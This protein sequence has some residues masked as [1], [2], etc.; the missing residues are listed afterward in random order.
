[1]P[2]VLAI[3]ALTVVPQLHLLVVPHMLCPIDGALVHASPEDHPHA[4]RRP[5]G[6]DE[7]SEP[8]APER[9]HGADE[10]CPLGL[11]SDAS[12]PTPAPL[13]LAPA[14]YPAPPVTARAS[15]PHPPIALI[16]LA[17]SHSP[18]A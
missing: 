5:G 18:P 11:L 10:R 1:M 3:F 4:A 7:G 15:V 17:P 9:P 12:G 13:Q 8:A 6:C 16:A 2:A 14:A